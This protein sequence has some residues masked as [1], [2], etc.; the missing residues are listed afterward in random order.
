MLRLPRFVSVSAVSVAALLGAAVC[1]SSAGAAAR[2]EKDAAFTGAIARA[3][4]DVPVGIRLGL[5]RIVKGAR[6]AGDGGGGGGGGRQSAPTVI[7]ADSAGLPLYVLDAGKDCAAACL[8]KWQPALAAPGAQP[9]GDF[10]TASLGSGQK[11]WTFQGKRLYTM[12]G[13]KS[14][15]DPVVLPLYRA[16]TP[17]AIGGVEFS[18]PGQDGMTLA[19]VA[20]FTWIKSPKTISTAEYRLVGQVLATGVTGNTP[21]GRP[22][23]VFKGTPE[24]EK[25]L[26]AT[27]QPLYASNLSLPVGDFTIRTRADAMPQWAYRG[28]SLYACSCDISTGDLNG[29]GA[30]PGIAPAVVIRYFNPPQVVVKRDPLSIGRMVEAS[31]GKT[32]Y[33]RDRTID[34]YVPDHARPLL[35]TVDA[36]VSALIGLKHCDVECEKEWRP[37]LAPK[38]AQPGGYWSLYDRPDGQ[39]QW[40]YKNAAVYTHASEGPGSLDGNETY[41]IAFDDGVGGEPWPIEFGIGMLWRALT[42]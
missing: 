8:Q 28:A 17:G 42:P 37:L 19:Q 24:Q 14:L 12:A 34:N 35:G 31:T 2:S 4:S 40:A 15:S 39:R 16:H 30:A 36:L 13:S 10:K 1:A 23:Y 33:F 27:F 7:F 38:N 25:A 5:A 26:P 20:P 3:R 6:P 41:D 22:L 9:A 11:Q 29:E 32:L 18:D 21:I